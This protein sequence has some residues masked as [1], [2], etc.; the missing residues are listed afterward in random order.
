MHPVPPPRKALLVP[1]LVVDGLARD[2]GFGGDSIDAGAGEAFATN[3]AAA[4]SRIERRLALWPRAKATKG[5]A[6]TIFI[7]P[8]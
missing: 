2:P 5:G 1:D 8:I 6:R 4:A 3:T 7:A